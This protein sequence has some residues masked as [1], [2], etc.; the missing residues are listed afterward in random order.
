MPRKKAAQVP[1]ENIKGTEVA[2]PATLPAIQLSADDLVA[3]W[4][5]NDDFVTAENKRFAEHMKPINERQETIKNLL[6]EKL[7]A[8]GLENF[9]TAHGTAYKS[10]ILNTKVDPD[11]APY[12]NPD[13]NEEVRGREAVLDF[14]LAHWD[15]IGNEMLMINVQKDSIENWMDAHDGNPPPGVSISR[16]TRINIRRS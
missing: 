5:R 9:K 3:E 10:H 14:A 16:F 13:T 12:I 2:I 8:E 11:G 7:N 15:E 4:I 6:Q 1:S